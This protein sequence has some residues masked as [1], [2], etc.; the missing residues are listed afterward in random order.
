MFSINDFF[1]LWAL[2]DQPVAPSCETWRI[3]PEKKEGM[4]N[5]ENTK[6]IPKLGLLCSD[7]FLKII[8]RLKSHVKKY[9]IVLILTTG[10]LISHSLCFIYLTSG[11]LQYK[12]LVLFNTHKKKRQVKI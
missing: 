8:Q 6:G 5:M 1:F 4:R 9:S 7:S 11:L 2:R 3:S 10:F 12:A